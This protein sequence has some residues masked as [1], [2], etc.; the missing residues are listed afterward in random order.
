MSTTKE[1][2]LRIPEA[3]REDTLAY[4]GHVEKFLAGETSAAAFR[5]YRVPMGIYEQRSAGSYMVRVRVG[6]GLVTAEQLRRIAEVSKKYGS[7][8]VHVTTRQDIQIHQVN[9]EDTPDILE[10]LLELGLSSRGGGGNTVRNVT[11][12]PRSGVCPKEEFD[13][14]PYAIATAEYLLGQ[15][16]S[17]NLP[18]KYKIAFSGCSVDC[19]YASVSDLGFFA[20]VVDG[21][22]GFSVYAGGGLGS[23]PAVA[24]KIEDYVKAEEVF[25]VAEAI[26]R[27]FDKYGDRSNK[28]KA[29][30]R[31]VLGRV[32]AEEFSRLYKQERADLVSK[33]QPG[34]IAV[35]RDAAFAKET[36][37]AIG[38]EDDK[39]FSGLA[40]VMREKGEGRFTVRLGLRHGYISADDVI[41]VGRIA[42]QFGGGIVR[43][44]Q[45]QDMLLTGIAR[46]DVDRVER[47]L[48]RLGTETVGEGEGDIVTCTGAATCKLGLCLSCGLA[49]AICAEFEKSALSGY[50]GERV[51]RISGCPNSCGQHYIGDIGFQGRAKRA[52][53]RLMPCYDVLVGGRAFEGE[54]RLAEVIGSV[55]ARRAPEFLGE[56]FRRGAFGKAEAAELLAQYS[57]RVSEGFGEEYYYDNGSE[58]P[59]SLS[60]RGPGECG[61]GVMDVIRVDID[62]AEEAVRRAGRASGRREKSEALYGGILA[63]ARALVVTFGVEPKTER[64]I[65]S[66]FGRHLIEGGWVRRETES[67]LE[68]AIEWRTG[69]RESLAD[70]GS[71]YD[72]LV[73]RVEELFVSLDGNL[74]F[75][76]ERV[77][78]EADVEEE[79]VRG[80]G[81]DLRGVSCPLN[82]V[83]AKVE[84]EKIEVGEVLDILLDEGEPARN[85]PES[86]SQQGQEVVEVNESGNYICVKVRRKR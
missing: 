5:A 7:E 74:E 28:H 61:A 33:G 70:L 43:T 16:S 76:A 32:G 1:R 81:I 65:F 80:H 84:L 17:F 51:I 24:V 52:G 22:K 68:A 64:E 54:A 41:E 53:G 6:A 40:N 13:V 29:R 86:F 62:E 63:A 31:Y 46:E 37:G 30:L 2:V 10:G 58:A 67:L 25:A 36:C 85:V 50:V 56:V 57:V 77:T 35:L 8:T 42:E 47:A 20:H 15:K 75:R 39:R 48:E 79:R 59:F 34:R 49:D 55:P 12:C 11:A 73:R 4:R 19:A 26:K 9:I 78:E 45:L 38:S 71:E 27:V 82:F 14:G 23:N 21:S 18:R 72:E 60:G 44:T 66:A 83:K 69:A 3:V